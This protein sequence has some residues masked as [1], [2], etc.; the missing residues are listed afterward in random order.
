M[1]PLTPRSSAR[2][3]M[4]P[5]VAAL[6]SMLALTLAVTLTP[7]Q[8]APSPAR[9]DAS[10]RAASSPMFGGTVFR[11]DGES[12][13]EG[14][15]RVMHTYGGL[16]AIRMFY[17]GL[18]ASWDRIRANV[19]RTP[20]VVSF[21]AD[22]G[23]IVAGRHDDHFTRWFKQ[24]PT[25]RPTHWSLWHEPEDDGV[26]AREYRRAWRHLKV[27]SRKADNPRL[28]STLILMCWTLDDASGRRWRTWY[29]G[30]ATIHTLA[31]DC[32][33]TGRKNGVYKRPADILRPVARVARRTDNQWG[34]GEFGS[35]VIASDGGTAG[36]ARWLRRY[37]SYVERHGGQFATYFDSH[38]GY[39]YRLHD[40]PSRRAWRSVVTR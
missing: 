34:I 4:T 25:H 12:F 8:G 20:V 18:P 40:S 7:A 29:P 30:D 2:A 35:T 24:A 38:V 15:D 5:L 37:A 13:A 27:L 23:D 16:D 28:K 6:V 26:D 19:G 36:R 14:Y 31:F 39:D 10:H 3:L 21:K 22:L 32:Y 9:D 11:N 33:N 17:P 1:P